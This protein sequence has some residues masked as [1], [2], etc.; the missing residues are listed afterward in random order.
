M[1]CTLLLLAVQSEVNDFHTLELFDHPADSALLLRSAITLGSDQASLTG[2]QNALISR[3][4]ADVAQLDTQEI[5][6]FWTRVEGMPLLYQTR[7]PP[8]VES[9]RARRAQEEEEEEEEEEDVISQSAY[10][11]WCL[12]QRNTSRGNFT[13]EVDD[14]SDLSLLVAHVAA[15]LIKDKLGYDVNLIS[16]HQVL[17]SIER[18]ALGVV[19]A[20]VE[21]QLT[22]AR[23]QAIYQHLVEEQELA[24]DLGPTGYSN[25]AGW[26]LANGHL[27]EEKRIHDE[28]C[29][30]VDYWHTF[31]QDHI[32]QVMLAANDVEPGI[33]HDGELV[34]D[35]TTNNGFCPT[36]TGKYFSRAC[37]GDGYAV[38]NTSRLCVALLA[39]Y[40]SYDQSVNEQLINNLNGG[41]EMGIVFLGHNTTDEILRRTER[42]EVFLFHHWYPSPLLA[43]NNFSQVFLP[44]HN[45]AEW[46]HQAANSTSGPISTEFAPG[47]IRKL[48][49]AKKSNDFAELREFLV[50]FDLHTY[51]VDDLLRRSVDLELQTRCMGNGDETS[52]CRTIHE[53][54]ACNWL[55]HNTNVWDNFMPE[56][57]HCDRGQHVQVT[58]MDTADCVSCT[59]GQ[60]MPQRSN[61]QSCFACEAG[62]FQSEAGQ[63]KCSLCVQGKYSTAI[64]STTSTDCHE[65]AAGKW[66]NEYGSTECF[67]CEPGHYQ[68]LPGQ[69]YCSTCS[70]GYYQSSE[71]KTI[72]DSCTRNARNCRIRLVDGLLHEDCPTGEVSSD[73]C[74]CSPGHYKN[75]SGSCLACPPGGY[76]CMCKEIAGC[77]DPAFGTCNLDLLYN[78][79]DKYNSTC[80]H[81]YSG[82]PKPLAMKGHFQTTKPDTYEAVFLACNLRLPTTKMRTHVEWD[83]FGCLGGPDNSSHCAE[84]NSGFLCYGCEKGMYLADT[85]RCVRC[86]DPSFSR[87]LLNVV[88]GIGFFVG[89]PLMF[90]AIFFSVSDKSASQN[91]VYPRMVIDLCTVLYLLRKSLFKYWPTELLMKVGIAEKI[92]GRAGQSFLER[93]NSIFFECAYGWSFPRRYVTYLLLPQILICGLAMQVGFVYFLYKNNDNSLSRVDAM[94]AD[95]SDFDTSKVAVAQKK[96]SCCS[97]F[98]TAIVKKLPNGSTPRGGRIAWAIPHDRS[99]WK[100]FK[101]HTIQVYLLLLILIYITLVNYSLTVFDCSKSNSHYEG[102]AYMEE[103]PTIPCWDLSDPEWGRLAAIAAIA[104]LGYTVAI[105]ATLLTIFVR[106]KESAIRGDM[107][108]MQKFGFLL[109]PYRQEC[110]Y[111][112]IVNIARKALLSCLVRMLTSQPFLC[113][114]SCA[115]VLFMILYH[116]AGARPYKY[117]KHNDCAMYILWVACLSF[118]SSLIFISDMPTM[119]VK[120]AFM[121]VNIVLIAVGLV[122]AVGGAIK[123]NVNFLYFLFFT[124]KCE[125]SFRA[126]MEREKM[127]LE[128][129]KP[130]LVK[131]QYYDLLVLR[132]RYAHWSLRA[133]PCSEQELADDSIEKFDVSV[134]NQPVKLKC[135]KDT[136]L[137]AALNWQKF[138]KNFAKFVKKVEPKRIDHRYLREI[139]ALDELFAQ[140]DEDGSGKLDRE[141]VRHMLDT[142]R[143]IKMSDTDLD[144]AMK[145]MAGTDGD[146]EITFDQFEAWYA[147][148]PLQDGGKSKAQIRTEEKKQD[149]D[150]ADL[151]YLTPCRLLMEELY[152]EKTLAYMI[153][154]LEYAIKHDLG[155]KYKL[156]EA[157]PSDVIGQVLQFG[158]IYMKDLLSGERVKATVAQLKRARDKD[159]GG[160]GSNSEERKSQ[161]PPPRDDSPR[162]KGGKTPLDNCYLIFRPTRLLGLDIGPMLRAMQSTRQRFQC[163]EQND[164]DVGFA[165]PLMALED[166]LQ[167]M[168]DGSNIFNIGAI[169]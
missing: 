64:E 91:M 50:N 30:Y 92:Q 74:S 39:H 124:S 2:A 84:G 70:T 44:T 160:W 37:T 137:N 101:N 134:D 141:E 95:G 103:S 1:V 58:N 25:Q 163:G 126:E 61:M 79:M 133:V 127:W 3:L 147:E 121:T 154:Y 148:Q 51:H 59:P 135:V 86:N 22:E 155:G 47:T 18:V 153:L 157:G 43:S 29:A 80:E 73:A 118:L 167:S 20:S 123:D 66:Q 75:A 110:Y 85:G 114:F 108:Y 68:P 31:A 109:K 16:R 23:D 36:G 89:I 96:I 63:A 116:Q 129:D 81:C 165:N 17:N 83:Y 143:A 88:L 41:L 26:F 107:S 152:D 78:N 159:D 119:A 60:Y 72:C 150:T 9:G 69:L 42:G 122:W 48:L 7:E 57:R 35:I 6:A 125:A 132:S 67:G 106:N 162:V 130:G 117:A 111:W 149:A 49:N 100:R 53:M 142:T 13:L 140:I 32:L 90:T 115:A 55:Q 28:H 112:E 113:G 146:S 138:H 65:C 139:N 76:C 8:V 40:P 33:T 164:E 156:N 102:R 11:G 136:Q 161:S 21:I 105:P 62:K 104:T 71:N 14:A 10:P 166:E 131:L 27:L 5:D 158:K 56:H 52:A 46:R 15:I 151:N 128:V 98:A 54:A 168:N 19:D 97:R 34:C 4:A 77:Y 144:S 24:L 87:N 12:S 99:G 38:T 94:D 145:E 169:Q 45:S 120:M 82:S 93:Y